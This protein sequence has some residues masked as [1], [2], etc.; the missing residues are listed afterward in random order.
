M[1]HLNLTLTLAFTSIMFFACKEQT[2]MPGNNEL[3][4][5]KE[6][7]KYADQ[8]LSDE[9]LTL[10]T[11]STEIDGVD[12]LDKHRFGKFF[13]DRAEFFVIHEP[14]YEVYSVKPKSI[15]L[16][17]LDGEL[18]QTKYI[19]SEDI[20]NKLL[21]EL[22]RASIIG[23]DFEN[24]SVIQTQP[25]LI[26]TE[27]GLRLNE[28]LNNFELKWTFGEKQIK[29]RVNTTGGKAEFSYLEKVKNYE[30]VFKKIEK[31]CI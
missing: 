10:K 7:I 22:G 17:Y 25:I 9:V 31:Y 4:H 11:T 30:R 27:Q 3:T 1:K 28:K 24:R 2:T 15:T 16:F 12:D 5:Q 8:P 18:S 19:L 21:N 26:S 23:C 6:T 14:Q 20:I 29:Y 13:C